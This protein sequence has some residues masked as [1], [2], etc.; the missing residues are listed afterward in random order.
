[1]PC[2]NCVDGIC[3]AKCQKRPEQQFF[4]GYNR[5]QFEVIDSP[6]NAGAGYI[7]SKHKFNTCEVS[8]IYL[9]NLAGHCGTTVSASDGWYVTLNVGSTQQIIGEQLT[10]LEAL[11]LLISKKEHAIPPLV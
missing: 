10:K 7:W 5:Y 3:Q 2:I 6:I 4:Y 8:P 11:N 1:M 9:F